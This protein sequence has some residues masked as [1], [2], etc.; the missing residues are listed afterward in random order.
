MA[1]SGVWTIKEA[2]EQAGLTEDTIRYYEK[3]GLLPR[4]ERR[5]NQHRRYR[6]ADVQVMKTINCLKKTGMSLEDMKPFLQLTLEDDLV[7]H[8]ELRELLVGHKQKIESQIAALQQIVDLID[9]KLEPGASP[10]GSGECALVDEKRM[11]AP[12]ARS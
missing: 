9:S 8:A 1:D 5:A 4:A 12:R 3:I 2:A 10:L 11:P 6:D 7:E